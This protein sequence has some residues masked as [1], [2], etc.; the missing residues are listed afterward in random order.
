M[1]IDYNEPI[2]FTGVNTVNIDYHHGQLRPV[3]GVQSIQLLR[4][5]REHPEAAEGTGWTYNHAPMLAYRNGKFYLEYLSNPI[6]EHQPPGHT[7]LAISGD[8]RSWSKPV[9]VFPQY[10]VPDGIFQYNGKRLPDNTYAVMHQR[11]GFY[12]APNGKLLVLGNYGISPTVDQVPFGQY[13]IGRV[14][15]EIY[16]DDTLGPIYFIRYTVNTVWNESN[17]PYPHYSKS[18]DRAFIEACESMLANP[19]ATQQWAE[20]QG[21]ADELI[22]L[23]SKDGGAL[24][25]KAFC[26]YKLKDGSVVGLWKWMKSAVSHDNGKT[27]SEVAD[28]PTVKHAGGKIWGQRTSD[29]KFAL[30]CN[31]HTNNKKRW[32][33]AILTGENGLEF[34]KMMCVIGD[35]SPQRYA[36]HSKD[37][38]FNYVRGIENGD[39]VGPDGATYVV[40]SMN[41]EDIWLSR[42]PVPIRDTVTEEVHDDFTRMPITAWVADWNIHSPQWAPTG[43]CEAPDQ[44]GRC[45]KL[46]DFD[47]YDYAK[48]ERVFKEGERITAAVILMAG[49]KDHGELHIEICDAKGTAP[50]KINLNGN[51]ELRIMH[52]RKNQKCLEYEA[53]KWYEIKILA[54]TVRSTFDVEIDGK[55]LSRSQQYQ[56]QTTSMTGWFFAAPVRSLERIVFRTG[57]FRREPNIDTEEIG[58]DLPLAGSKD[59]SAVYY[60]KN[61]VIDSE[62]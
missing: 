42:I 18:D 52:G 28:I 15:R 38:G 56:G 9:I 16:P 51:G 57:P 13:S 39:A 29:D 59:R 7:L 19:L 50:I 14:V 44:S 43:I 33:L 23:K 49:Q 60:I 37:A 55:S 46:E 27:W 36:G 20:E 30:V 40:Y 12:E 3:V 61:L 35:V 24:Y 6:H 2:K 17:T 4:A 34:D 53:G 58:T 25:N 11:H 41:K 26:W 31:P 45:L 21:D 48:A 5:N 1:K 54:D 32:P 62:S 22:T 47:R 10:R 8:G